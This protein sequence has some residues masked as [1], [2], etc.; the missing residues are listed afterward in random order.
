M[1][2]LYP[3]PL[4]K[5]VYWF[6]EVFGVESSTFV[7]Y[8]II[9]SANRN[10]I[11]MLNTMQCI[12]KYW[13]TRPDCLQAQEQLL[14]GLGFLTENFWL[15]KDTNNLQLGR[16]EIRLGQGFHAWGLREDHKGKKERRWREGDTLGQVNHETMA[17][18]A[19]GQLELKSSR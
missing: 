10:R 6:Q 15:N 8:R 7:I 3:V 13:P 1:Y 12:V 11:I 14:W 5:N 17:M 2:G 19:A 16:R 18:R 4:Q 9:F